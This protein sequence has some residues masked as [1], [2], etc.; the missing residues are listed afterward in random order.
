ML[1]SP[2]ANSLTMPSKMLSPKRLSS[3]ILR[4]ETISSA[5]HSP[6]LKK[7]LDAKSQKVLK[8]LEIKMQPEQI[9]SALFRGEK[10]KEKDIF[11]SI[12]A[13]SPTGE[14]RKLPLSPLNLLKYEQFLVSAKKYFDI[15][16][17]IGNEYDLSQ[18]VNL[19]H[20]AE[21]E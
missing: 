20:L 4:A 5:A 18:T 11:K 6:L 17:E 15:G 19:K 3:R 12:H 13:F 9:F 21:K 10:V 16:I 14:P 2:V 7:R 1:T 8:N